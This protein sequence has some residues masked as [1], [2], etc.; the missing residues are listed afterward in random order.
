MR[1]AA[2][3][4]LPD[5]SARTS[6]S[7]PSPPSMKIEVVAPDRAGL[8]APSLALEALQTPALPRQRLGL[9]PP[10]ELH[11]VSGA[12]LR[13]DPL[14]HAGGEGQVVEGDGG[15]RRHGAQEPP[16]LAR[17]GLLGEARAEH[18]SPRSSPWTTQGT[19]QSGASGRSDGHERL[20]VVAGELARPALARDLGEA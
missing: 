3:K 10:G 13:L 4:P 18:D 6:P 5:T 15:L 8:D 16:V 7:R 11:L 14:R 17:V 2:A 1:S 9:D 12:A 20:A 19:R